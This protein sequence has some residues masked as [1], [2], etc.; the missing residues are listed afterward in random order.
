MIFN[1]ILAGNGMVKNATINPAGTSIAITEN[2]EIPTFTFSGLTPDKIKSGCILAA[3]TG[4][5]GSNDY[6]L[7]F[8]SKSG[9]TTFV[10]SGTYNFT[11]A[12]AYD[13][14]AGT[15]AIT[16]KPLFSGRDA[17]VIILE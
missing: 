11:V 4:G 14:V 10:N 6:G 17:F 12:Q 3:T 5:P 16:S 1:P 7:L 15:F 8:I 2:H 9:E 13:P